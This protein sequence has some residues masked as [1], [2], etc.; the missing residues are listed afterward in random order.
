MS[1]LILQSI[2][3]RVFVSPARRWSTPT[4]KVGVK[5]RHRQAQTPTR[6]LR[7]TK[8]SDTKGRRNWHLHKSEQRYNNR[9]TLKPS[10][11]KKHDLILSFEHI[12]VSVPK[13]LSQLG[14]YNRKKQL[15]ETNKTDKIL[16]KSLRILFLKEDRGENAN[17]L[18]VT[19]QNTSTQN[20]L[21]YKEGNIYLFLKPRSTDLSKLT[22]SQQI[23]FIVMV[24]GVFVLWIELLRK[25][26]AHTLRLHIGI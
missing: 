9:S 8:A 26:E 23:F 7:N 17:M 4:P 15:F 21:I 2:V 10:Y 22:C 16:S 25:S 18:K 19:Q 14:V 13:I 6:P 20:Q 1:L 11:I 5:L 24:S 3:R 12:S